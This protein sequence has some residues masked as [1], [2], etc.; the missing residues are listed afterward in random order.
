MLVPQ[1]TQALSQLRVDTCSV[2][3]IVVPILFPYP[4]LLEEYR[5]NFAG[6]ESFKEFEMAK[7][8]ANGGMTWGTGET[9]GEEKGIVG[10]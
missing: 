2:M 9:R 5:R 3:R 8:R 7:W 1:A 10:K 4:K 6:P